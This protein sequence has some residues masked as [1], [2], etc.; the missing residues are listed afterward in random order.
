MSASLASAKLL[1]D[2]IEVVENR[3]AVARIGRD[4]ALTA[5]LRASPEIAELRDRVERARQEL[6]DLTW[7]LTAIGRS[8]LPF[9]WDGV[10][11]GPDRGSGA[12]W[13]AALA[14]LETDPDA[15]LPA[16]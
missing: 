6:H 3:R 15:P 2:E 1:R 8:R 5:V 11:S 12:P 14:A 13:K 16:E 4:T 7:I 10:L 9:H